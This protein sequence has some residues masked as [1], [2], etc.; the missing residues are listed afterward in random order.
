M[1]QKACFQ[2]VNTLS[3][4]NRVGAPQVKRHHPVCFRVSPKVRKTFILNTH[5]PNILFSVTQTNTLPHLSLP[6][7]VFF[8]RMVF[9]LR[10]MDGSQRCVSVSYALKEAPV[11]LLTIET[12]R[13]PAETRVSASAVRP[14]WNIRFPEISFNCGPPVNR[15]NFHDC[16]ASQAI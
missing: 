1:N 15:V 9:A 16:R 4:N 13:K 14:T 12:I 11:L 7:E 6:V 8:I 10:R 5:L 3:S 2:T